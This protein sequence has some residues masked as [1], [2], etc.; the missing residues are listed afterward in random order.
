MGVLYNG[1]RYLDNGIKWFEKALIIV[2]FTAAVAAG[3]GQ[4]V[5]RYLL[6][7]SLPWSEELMRYILIWLSF[8]AASLGF[9]MENIHTNVD[10]LIARFKPRV[11]AVFEIIWR[12]ICLVFTV[13]TSALAIT[14]LQGS[15]VSGQMTAAMR[16]P[17]SVVYSGVVL[18][19]ILMSYHVFVA[20][21]ER[22]VKLFSKEEKGGE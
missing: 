5:A 7:Q 3:T 20:I 16:L 4:V 8:F 19:F 21:V 12:V 11:R 22:V 1:L 18:A 15:I 17:M 2:L 10:L 14:M 13:S 9:T 6:N